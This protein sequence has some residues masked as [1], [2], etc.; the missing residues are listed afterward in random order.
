MLM[1]N[2]LK[3]DKCV[4]ERM[5]TKQKIRAFLGQ[6]EINEY[7]KN[8]KSQRPF[9][10]IIENFLIHMSLYPMIVSA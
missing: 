9:F 8:G 6:S 10:I 7:G 2:L 1:M 5:A 4:H 3:G